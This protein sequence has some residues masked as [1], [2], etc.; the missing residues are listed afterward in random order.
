MSLTEGGL[1]HPTFSY[2]KM[3]K[4]NKIRLPSGQG[5]LVTYFNELKSKIEFSPGAVVALIIFIIILM[6]IL[7]YFGGNLLQ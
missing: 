6:I 4:D 3:A 2:S 5:G 7:H 1:C